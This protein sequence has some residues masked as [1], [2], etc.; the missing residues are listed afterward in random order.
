MRRAE[1]MPNDPL[2]VPS[3][4]RRPRGLVMVLLALFVALMILS[5]VAPQPDLLEMVSQR[6]TG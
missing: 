1:A 5:V 6:A 4:R 3:S 2:K